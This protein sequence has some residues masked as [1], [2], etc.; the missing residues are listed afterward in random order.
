[1]KE[2][3]IK[4]KILSVKIDPAITSYGL[5]KFL[6]SSK[7]KCKFIQDPIF[8]LKSKKNKI[9][10]QNLK[11]VHMFDGVALVKLFFWLD[12]FKNKKN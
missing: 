4:T 5:I 12:Y 8:Y 9:E 11:I 10:I 6:Q 2:S 1:M 3:L 7:I